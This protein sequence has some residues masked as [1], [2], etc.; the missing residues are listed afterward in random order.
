MR[1]KYGEYPE[2]HTSLDDLR[3]VTPDGLKGGYDAL[4]K[5]LEVIEK[6]RVLRT[7]V[8]GEPQ[9]GR[10]GLYPTISKK[11]S[12]SHVRKMM[13]MIAYCDGQHSLLEVA[14]RIGEPFWELI[15]I[16]EKLIEHGILEDVDGGM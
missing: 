1:T 12:A 8:L 13:N 10:R 9:L 5:A 14:D 3:L 11:G 2:Y 16:A 15:P 4:R 7:T 6:D